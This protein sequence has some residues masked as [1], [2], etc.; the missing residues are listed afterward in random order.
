MIPFTSCNAVEKSKFRNI[1]L[2]N[3]IINNPKT[4]PGVLLGG[5]DNTI[6]GI[7][8]DNV[9]A[10]KGRPI[11][12][13][14]D[15]ESLF[16]G[17]QLP[18]HDP[19]LL[20]GRLFLATAII[21]LALSCIA[22]K[23]LCGCG[24]PP[25]S[26]PYNRGERLL[27]EDSILV[28]DDISSDVSL[29]DSLS[30]VEWLRQPASKIRSV[31]KSRQ[32]RILILTLVTIIGT[33][34]AWLLIKTRTRRDISNYFT[35]Q[36]V[37]GGVATGGTWP[38]PACFLDRTDTTAVI[39]LNPGHMLWSQWAMLVIG[40]LSLLIVCRLCFSFVLKSD[41]DQCVDDEAATVRSRLASDFESEAGRTRLASADFSE[42][43][44]VRLSTHD[45]E[46]TEAVD[47]LRT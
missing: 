41:D 21:M 6:E 19:E 9:V 4:S 22:L 36:G 38:V 33:F 47:P 11:A 28:E 43:G 7:V 2:R 10:T 18:I 25:S 8:F 5:D 14:R 31:P 44:Y 13:M 30:C 26:P 27:S 3:I 46:D 37:W 40:A 32:K 34:C 45:E 23:F 16:P 20:Q 12:A 42:A 39:I 29:V 1:T 15:P 35:C 24:R 17:R